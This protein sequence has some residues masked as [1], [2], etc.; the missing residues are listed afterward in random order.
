M[1]K[2]MHKYLTRH[3]KLLF[4]LFHL[5]I[6]FP[7]MC[8]MDKRLGYYKTDQVLLWKYTKVEMFTHV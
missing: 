1:I 4:S 8:E 2:K 6:F 5:N 7:N 3:S